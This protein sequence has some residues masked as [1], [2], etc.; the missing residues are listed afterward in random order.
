M[1]KITLEEFVSHWDRGTG[2][3]SMSSLFAKNIGDFTT[4]AGDYSR[5]RFASSFAEGGFYGSGTKWP[6]RTSK[7][8]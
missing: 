1:I 8:D 4:R 5:S 7:W 6:V 3:R 2:A